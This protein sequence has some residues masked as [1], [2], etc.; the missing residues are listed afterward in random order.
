[1][2]MHISPDNLPMWMI[3]I[4]LQMENELRELKKENMEG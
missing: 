3:T 4:L 1:M 2:G